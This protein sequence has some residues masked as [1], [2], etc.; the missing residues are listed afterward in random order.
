MRLSSLLIVVSAFGLAAIVSIVAAT[1]SADLI[2]ETSRRSVKSA[3]EDKDMMWTNVHAEGLQVFLTGVAPTEANRFRALSTAGG[4]V[5]AAR[6]I[7]NMQVEATADLAPPRFSVEILR[8]DSGIQLIGLIP[9]SSDRMALLKSLNK[10][11]G[12]PSVTDFLETADYRQPKGWEQA[13]GFALYALQH[14]PRT[15]ISVEAGKVSVTAM[16][17]SAEHRDEI[18]TKLRRKA[19]AN[20]QLALSISAPRPVITPFTLRF[21]KDESGVRFDACSAD[22]E[23]AQRRILETAKT[24]GLGTNATCTIGLGVPTP[25]WADA[26]VIALKGVAGLGGGSVTFSDADITLVSLEGTDQAVFDR[27]IGEMETSLPDVFA[28]H[29]TLPEPE[30]VNEDGS[31]PEFTATLSPEG[32]LQLRGR[33]SDDLSR[34]TASNYARAR[35]GSDSVHMAARLDSELPAN[36]TLRV[37]AGLDALAELHNGALMITPDSLDVRGQTGDPEANARISQML[38]DRLLQSDKFSIDVSYQEKLDPI[39]LLP[40]PEECELAVRNILKDQKITFEPGSGTLDPSASSIIDQIATVLAACAEAK[41]EIQGHTDSQGREEMNQALSQT[42][43][44]SVLNALH[45]RRI[46]TNSFSAKGY[47]ESQAIADN[48]TEEGREANRRIEF[49]L[50]RPEPTA[51]E[52]TA[53]EEAEQVATA[54]DGADAAADTE[55]AASS[56]AE[57]T[58][59]DSGEATQ[60]ESTDDQN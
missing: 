29:S 28:L 39:A 48:E 47:G 15:K 40:T 11:D 33:L 43:A 31:I 34:D 12:K 57:T 19:P 37:M 17:D 26:V 9:E 22:S 14:L 44:Q 23:V 35:F 2:E 10:L 46:L 6:V 58:T 51:E 36:W 41:L 7:D 42:R 49:V 50:I 18:E 60:Q 53:L 32:L 16:S 30:V 56:E 24:A 5:D 21:V 45:E 54:D 3:L 52:A 4:I 55:N 8:N 38:A 13:T 59:Q 25:A 27:V 1:F 20:L